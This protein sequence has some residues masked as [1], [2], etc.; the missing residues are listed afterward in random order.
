MSYDGSLRVWFDSDISFDTEDGIGADIA[1]LP[2]LIASRSHKRLREDSR[3]RIKLD[4]KLSV[5]E[6]AIYSIGR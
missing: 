4:V 2:R 5:V 3:M 6:L 1:S